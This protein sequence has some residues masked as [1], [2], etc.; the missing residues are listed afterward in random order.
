MHRNRQS[1]LGQNTKS[2]SAK[3]HKGAKGSFGQNFMGQV[4]TISLVM[5]MLMACTTS[6]APNSTQTN[7]LA[8]GQS[9]TFT[10]AAAADLQFAF[11]EL[12]AHFEQTTGTHVTLVFGSTGQLV[13]QIENGAPYDVIAAA[14]VTYIDQLQAAGLVDAD[15]VARY[16]RGK[17]VLAVNRQADV[18]ATTPADLLA[19]TI[20]HIAL[21]NPAHAPYG[22]AARQALEAAGVWEKLQEKLVF[23]ENVRQTLQFVQSGEVEVAIVARSVADVPEITWTLL[24]ESLYK[25]LDQALAIVT[26]SPNKAAAAQFTAL[27]LSDQGRSVLKKYGFSLPQ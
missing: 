20:R 24:D 22:L 15:T 21:A 2:F 17:I 23:A 3:R 18:Q 11:S 19:P 4:L 5:A 12:A 13:Q 1:W 26:A 6:I 9:A 14:N 7:P 10:V 16:A 8:N 27:V 25:P